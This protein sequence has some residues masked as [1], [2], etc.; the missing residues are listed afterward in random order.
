MDDDPYESAEAVRQLTMQDFG[1]HSPVESDV[2][3]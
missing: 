1:I 3:A 2:I